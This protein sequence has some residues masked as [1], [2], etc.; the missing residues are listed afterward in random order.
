MR[1][2]I[3]AGQPVHGGYTLARIDGRIVL[4]EGAAPGEKVEIE[5]DDTQ[6]PWRGTVTAVHE[7]SADRVPHIWDVAGGAELGYLKRSAQL[8]WKTAVLNDAIDHLGGGLAD[9]LKQGGLTVKVNE[10]GPG[11]GTRTR[12]DLEVDESGKLAMYAHGTNTLVPID[13]MPL[14]APAINDIIADQEAWT[15]TW[16]PGDSVRILA[17]SGQGPAVAV[18]KDVYRAP[19]Q[20]TSS[21]VMERAAGYTW[22][23]TATGFWQTHEK[24]P[25]TLLDAV[26][27]GARLRKSDRVAE[28]YGGAGLF[29]LPLTKQ[30]RA[31]RMWEGNAGAV[32]DA[33][34]NAPDAKITQSP[35]NAKVLAE[36]SRGADVV[37]ADPSRSGLGIPGAKAL[38]ASDAQAIALVSCD[39]AALAR[40]VSAMVEE[41]RTVQSLAS[42]DL[43]PHTMHI[44]AVTIL[45]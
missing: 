3:E 19:G 26:I 6:K 36:G 2:D 17:P 44:E 39:P 10:V 4:V 25:V 28:F 45:S 41:G 9:H 43:F 38:S 8:D 37:I 21:R 15:G 29:T 42:Y 20:K 22:E 16:Q 40:D 23:V 14:A 33:K 32:R 27:K 1:I 31:V 13:S 12:L 5:I 11:L 7:P 35:I 24:A 34:R 18:G 30:A